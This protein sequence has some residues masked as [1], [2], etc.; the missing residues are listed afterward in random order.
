M[1]FLLKLC[2]ISEVKQQLNLREC[3]RCHW[4]FSAPHTAP[5]YSV[6]SSQY[7]LLFSSVLLH[8]H[9][10][11]KAPAESPDQKHGDV[12]AVNDQIIEHTK[13]QAPVPKQKQDNRELVLQPEED[14][15]TDVL[16]EEECREQHPKQGGQQAAAKVEEEAQEAVHPAGAQVEIKVVVF[17]AHQLGGVR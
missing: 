13:V 2:Q 12:H 10:H 11:H 1:N 16:Q 17:G 3:Y 14:A 5:S 9:K 15:H 6:M 8:V 7:A 4:D